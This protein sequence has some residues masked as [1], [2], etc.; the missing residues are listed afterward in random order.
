M[1]ASAILLSLTCTTGDWSRDLLHCTRMV[2]AV[3]QM[4]M[5]DARDSE[6]MNEQE[7]LVRVDPS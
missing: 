3:E 6:E 2:D 1:S 4:K 7:K 5:S